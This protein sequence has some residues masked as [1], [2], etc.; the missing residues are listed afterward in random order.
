MAPSGAFRRGNS[1]K[2]GNR[3]H[4]AEP[5]SS[6]LS[7]PSYRG[8]V[9]RAESVIYTGPVIGGQ[10]TT[11]TPTRLHMRPCLVVEQLCENCHEHPS[12]EDAHRDKPHKRP[13]WVSHQNNHE[14]E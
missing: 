2:N 10:V 3:K 4:R 7:W 12:L 1:R 5:N 6:T 11:F 9:I 13:A 14:R 8:R